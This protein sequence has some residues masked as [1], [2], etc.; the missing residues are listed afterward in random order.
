MLYNVIVVVPLYRAKVIRSQLGT[1]A[2]KAEK[3]V[4]RVYSI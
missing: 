3:S 2:E 4:N 1:R